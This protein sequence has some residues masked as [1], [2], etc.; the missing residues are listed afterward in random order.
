MA[1]IFASMGVIPTPF[2][3][4]PKNSMTGA[5]RLI[6]LGA[7]SS[8]SWRVLVKLCTRDLGVGLLYLRIRGY[9]RR[10]R[11]RIPLILVWRGW[12]SWLLGSEREC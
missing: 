3:W 5:Q 12:C 10:S 11:L 6:W 1:A 7:S 8:G 4:N 9:R 2:T